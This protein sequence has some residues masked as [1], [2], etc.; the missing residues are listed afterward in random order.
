MFRGEERRDLGRTDGLHVQGAFRRQDGDLLKERPVCLGRL[1][2]APGVPTSSGADGEKQMERRGTQSER[3]IEHGGK[4]RRVPVEE[5][6]VYLKGKAEGG[7]PAT[8]RHGGV[9]GAIDTPEEIVRFRV[10]AVEAD[11]ARASPAL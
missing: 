2:D 6:H 3:Q 9:P 1:H 10:N 7:T 4:F 8:G 5:G 11:P